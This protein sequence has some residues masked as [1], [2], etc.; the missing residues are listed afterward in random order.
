MDN[1]AFIINVS[2]ALA[3]GVL[4]G[5]ERELRQHPAGLRVN[6]LA[7]FGAALFVSM[8]QLLSHNVD[9]TRIVGQ[10]VT[11]VGF[12]AGGVIFREGLSVHGLNTATTLWC[13]AAV[14]SLAGCGFLLHATLATAL[15]LLT[16]IIF[17]PVM[18]FVGR[19]AK[20]TPDLTYVYRLRATCPGNEADAVR[21]IFLRNLSG[22]PG[23]IIQ[24]LAI[25][26]PDQAGNATV[27]V[28][29][30][31]HQRNDEVIN[32]L[33]ARIGVEP[34]VIGLSWDRTH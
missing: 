33:V 34:T 31:T 9:P 22:Q 4:I 19:H 1:T 2:V 26:P 23:L 30:F 7:C 10:V 25:Q 29:V 21:G 16:H 6:A 17:R 14:G 15:V 11:G 13:A 28:D 20:L 27:V 12:L 8:A 18:N 24:S 5:L 32:N 3:L